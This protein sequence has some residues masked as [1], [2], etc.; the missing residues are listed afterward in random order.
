MT[1]NSL[2]QPESWRPRPHHATP[3]RS[4]SCTPSVSFAARVPAWRPFPP[5]DQP[6]ALRAI[7]AELCDEWV[8]SSRGRVVVRGVKQKM[9]NF[10]LRPRGR[11]RSRFLDYTP[12]IIAN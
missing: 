12:Q 3:T 1:F 5:E 7:V 6:R 9:S 4:P 2:L 11:H 8:H 10:P